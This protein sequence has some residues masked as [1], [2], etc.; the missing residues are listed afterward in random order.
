MMFAKESVST[1][2]KWKAVDGQTT[3]ID[4]S[5][6]PFKGIILGEEEK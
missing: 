3:E 5:F 6:P 4:F 2:H 1:K